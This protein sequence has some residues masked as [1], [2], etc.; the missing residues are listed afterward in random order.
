MPQ[1]SPQTS[2]AAAE[3]GAVK[4]IP[5]QLPATGMLI[6]MRG[7]R[8]GKDGGRPTAR[9][10]ARSCRSRGQKSVV[11]IPIIHRLHRGLQE[12]TALR[13]C[14]MCSSVRSE[15]TYAPQPQLGMFIA[16]TRV[17]R[18][19]QRLQHRLYAV[20]GGEGRPRVRMYP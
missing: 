14:R 6:L 10:T 16:N 7:S 9:P 11:R 20:A 1:R 5:G 13:R 2:S 18:R 19:E 12:S 4:L 17:A 3:S 8:A 15:S